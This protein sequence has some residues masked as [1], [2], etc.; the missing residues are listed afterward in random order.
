MRSVIAIM[1]LAGAAMV[2]QPA[3]A[4]TID[5]MWRSPDGKRGSYL[6]V[7]VHPCSRDS[8]ARCAVVIAAFAG[9]KQRAV[10]QQVMRDM[11]RQPDGTWEGTVIQPLKG[12]VYSSRI[13][14]AG[15]GAMIVEGCVLGMLLCRKQKWTRVTESSSG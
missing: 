7:Q 11:V 10:G 2:C 1:T 5:G 6:H 3:A 12:H 9:A 13:S 15:A 4:E 14:P 8:D